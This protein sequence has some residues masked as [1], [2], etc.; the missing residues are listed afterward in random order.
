M[1]LSLKTGHEVPARVYLESDVFGT[2]YFDG[3]ETLSECI[4]AVERLARDVVQL[5]DGVDRRVGLAFG[6]VEA[7]EEDGDCDT[8]DA[9]TIQSWGKANG[10]WHLIA[11]ITGQPYGT[12][13]TCRASCGRTIEAGSRTLIDLPTS[14]KP[15]RKI[16]RACTAILRR[17]G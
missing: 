11:K 6:G 17:K 9:G 16:C 7:D 5:K 15:G 10:V 4:Q 3:Y 2:E 14:K 12:T 8:A 13:R 1:N